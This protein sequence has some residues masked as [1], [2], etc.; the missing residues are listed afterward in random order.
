M[1]PSLT[2]S[3]AV[4][5]LGLL[6]P[7]SS[8][9]P[10]DLGSFAKGGPSE[11]AVLLNQW[12]ARSDTG[13]AP[14]LDALENSE[15]WS[16][17]DGRLVR[18]S[19]GAE[20]RDAVTDSVLG[21]AAPDWEEV[22]VSNV[23]RAGV[24]GARASLRLSL[25]DASERLEAVKE[26]V[27]A[28]LDPAILPVL[29]KAVAAEKVPEIKALLQG[30]VSKIALSSDEPAKRIA[31]AK[32]LGANGDAS[33]NLKLLEERLGKGDDGEPLETDSTVR[34]TLSSVAATLRVKVWFYEMTGHLFTGVSL[35]SIL[36]LVALGLAI[37][38]GLLGVIN[39]AHGELVMIGAYTTY[40]VQGV[41]RGHFPAAEPFY[42][43][44]AIPAAFLVSA[45]VGVA[46]ERLILRHLYGRPLESL[47]ATWGV[48]LFL[49]QSVRS[50][51]G[52]QNVEV[53]SPSWLSGS[54]VLQS[55][56]VLPWNRLAIIA[57]AGLVLLLTALLLTRTRLGLFIRAT[58]QNRTMARCVGVR[59]SVVDMMAFGLGS[60]LAGLAGVALS[61]V[62]NVGPDL[63]QGYIVDSFLVVVVGGVGQLAGSLWAGLGLGMLSK[64]LEPVIGAVLAKIA[65]LVLIILFIQ[66]RPQG[67][68]ALKGRQAD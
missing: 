45:L 9:A 12:A 51:F 62:G 40:L 1:R 20:F 31:A 4:L 42:I 55:N 23:L 11:R 25:P 27:E 2:A 50:L 34:A 29:E 16:T 36:V 61:Q 68:F 35:G 38:Y 10:E 32:A 30:I 41:F 54:L 7:A 13:L 67:L 8:L 63:G 18:T 43:L 52:P 53:A 59:T 17:P 66:K 33:N 48:S 14:F 24:E 49:I 39:M 26:L 56:L 58:T 44:A 37:T 19:D 46:L 6:R 5:V 47:L 57:F 22:V 15:F 64:F 21:A 28:E 60:G 65:L 3:A